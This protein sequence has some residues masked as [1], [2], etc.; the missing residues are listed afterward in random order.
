M[1][2]LKYGFIVCT[3][4]LLAA[5]V[6]VTNPYMQPTATAPFATIHGMEKRNLLT[7]KGKYIYIES[8]DSK[9][10][11]MLW[12]SGSKIRLTPGHH[13]I[14]ADIGYFQF[15]LFKHDS[16]TATFNLSFNAIAGE[17]YTLKATIQGEHIFTW[18]VD[19]QGRAVSS[20][21]KSTYLPEGAEVV[22]VPEMKR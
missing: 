1:K 12:T 17:S 9:N 14:K 19:S 22:K 21:A 15:G 18:I 20:K 8:I 5:C 2:Y 6:P 7:S 13:E 16:Q 10:I 3:L 4:L 11:G